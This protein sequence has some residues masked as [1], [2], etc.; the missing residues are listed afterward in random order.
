VTFGKS[1]IVV[2]EL[3]PSFAGDG[4]NARAPFDE[5]CEQWL[6]EA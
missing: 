3:T 6:I 2:A 5:S 4:C 1:Q